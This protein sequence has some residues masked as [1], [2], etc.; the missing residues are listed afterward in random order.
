MSGHCL[1]ITRV[2]LAISIEVEAEDAD[3]LRVFLRVGLV[4]VE[5]SSVR[6]L[7]RDIR[8][9]A[10]SSQ[11]ALVTDRP[12]GLGVKDY[13]A[14]CRPAKPGAVIIVVGEVTISDVGAGDAV[15]AIG[16][17]DEH[18]A[19]RRVAGVGVADSVLQRVAGQPG[20]TIQVLHL[21]TDAQHRRCGDRYTI[22]ELRGI[23]VRISRCG[24][25]E[26]T[27]QVAVDHYAGSRVAGPIGGRRIRVQIRVPLAESGGI[28]YRV[29]EELDGEI[30]IRYAVQHTSNGRLASTDGG[31]GQHREVLQVVGSR[32]GVIVIIGRHAVSPQINA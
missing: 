1:H 31:G 26:L 4:G 18:P 23:A 14:R 5:G 19:G 10:G 8:E 28:A 30:R 16:V 15:G 24:G 9:G 25:Y 3:R 29:G 21:F 32:V 12:T 11:G 22:G 17:G 6:H 7:R 13:S 27:G 2:H 20:P